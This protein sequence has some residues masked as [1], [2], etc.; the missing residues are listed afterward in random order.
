MSSLAGQVI[1]HIP[2]NNPESPFLNLHIG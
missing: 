2:C 1:C